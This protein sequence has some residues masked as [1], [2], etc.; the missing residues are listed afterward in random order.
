MK[1]PRVF[2]PQPQDQSIE[3]HLSIIKIWTL[4]AILEGIVAL[5]LFFAVPSDP[6]NAWLLGFSKGRLVIL[7]GL[8]GL[9]LGFVFLAYRAWRSPSW[10]ERLSNTIKHILGPTFIYALL[11]G[12]FLVSVLITSQFFHFSGVVSDPYVKGILLRLRP[13]IFWVLGLSLQTLLALPLI[14]YGLPFVSEAHTKRILRITCFILVILVIFGTAAALTGIGILPD[15][16]GW[17]A[18]GVPILHIQL[19]LVWLL[20]LFFFSLEAWLGARGKRAQF[21]FD[22]LVSLFLW[23]LA[24]FL[25]YK[26]PLTP[27]YFAPKPRAPNY[28]YYPYSDAALHDVNAQELLI[29]EGFPGISRKPLYALFLALLHAV[30]GQDY[31]DI[32]NIQVAVL[33]FFPVL[34]YWLTKGLH[35]RISGW[36]A[37]GLIIFREQNA[38]ALS[39]DIRVS[40]AKLMMSDLPAALAI[41][42]ITWMFISWLQDPGK[43]RLLPLGIGGGVGLLML[44]RPQFSM[45][46]PAIFL[47]VLLFFY[48]RLKFGLHSLGWITLG[49]LLT[50][51]PWL[52]RSYQISGKFTLN[53]PS[54]MAFLT[55]QYHLDPQTESVERLAGESEAEYM[56]KINTYMKDFILEHPR[57][58]AGFISS[59]FVH[60]EIEM[61]QVLPMSFW[62]VSNPDSDLFP[63]WRQNWLKLWDD[64]C[65]IQT[66]VNAVGYWDP[67]RENFQPDQVLPLLLNLFLISLGLAVALQHQGIVGWIPLA[68]SLIYSFSTAVGRYSG[69]RL[70]L[71]ADWV[72]FTYFSIGLGQGTIWLRERYT[73]A[74][75]VEAPDSGKQSIWEQVA[76]LPQSLKFPIGPAII[77]S[78]ILLGVGL[79][80][81]IVETA[82]PQRYSPVTDKD[83]SAS[84]P[85]DDLELQD[86]LAAKNALVVEGRALYPRFYRAGDGEPGKSWTAFLEHD[87]SRLGFF[88]VGPKKGSVIIRME[89][90]PEYFPHAVDVVVV[91]C[92]GDDFI[93]A[94]AVILKTE[95]Q[96]VDTV[97][98]RSDL[99]NLSCPLP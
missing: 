2:K 55:E 73:G 80:P 47:L 96:P 30:A 12:L 9:L 52:W 64:C 58:V 23:G 69:W 21:R 17:D 57:L 79:T 67:Q 16:A 48:K 7:A 65:S 43:R 92:Q 90:S 53:D 28:E 46:I 76:S 11:V 87:Y 20:G 88:L 75:R 72:V 36:I 35:K 61:V 49:L 99:E 86:F 5:G 42:I 50:L 71:P 83:L 39:G 25:W 1:S 13:L 19:S 60:N 22:L 8:L 6:S 91:G 77:I 62:V 31:L 14:R 38:I 34:I 26:E 54:Q 68:F 56:G 44:L 3:K 93:D 51:S 18:P 97:V 45:L 32:V 85:F 81:L 4:A 24:F 84:M 40:H 82:V 66:Y 27:D 70:I 95:N 41:V 59:H 15:K 98:F 94:V 37:A 33:A 29:G 10:A 89:D 74:I 78:L 63:H